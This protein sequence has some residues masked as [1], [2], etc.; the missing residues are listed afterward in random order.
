MA[1]GKGTGFDGLSSY[2]TDVDTAIA[3]ADRIASSPRRAEPQRESAGDMGSVQPVHRDGGAIASGL[4]KVGGWALAIGVVLV[5]KACIYDGVHAVAD[6]GSTD[7]YSTAGDAPSVTQPE[8]GQGVPTVAEDDAD[9]SAMSKPTAAS[10]T[11]TMPEL[12]Y[13][14]AEDIRISAQKTELDGL[15]YTDPERFNR[16]VD[17]FNGAVNDYNISCSNRMFTSSDRPVA[18]S[19]VEGQRSS[20]EAEG[21]NRVD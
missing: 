21:R 14:I 12:R 15:Q 7:S 6:R 4:K 2:A 19:Q 8:E 5:I 1:G 16:N 9:T 13:C 3:E 11:L 20:L 18:T 17:G 10:G